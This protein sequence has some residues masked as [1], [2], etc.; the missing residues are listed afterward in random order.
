L[1]IDQIVN[2]IETAAVSFFKVLEEAKDAGL[3]TVEYEADIIKLFADC[4]T[5]FEVNQSQ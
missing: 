1:N 2:D 3:N 5:E 4:T